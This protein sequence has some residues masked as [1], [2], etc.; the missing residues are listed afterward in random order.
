MLFRNPASY[1]TMHEA[2]K[3]I[4]YEI[5]ELVTTDPFIDTNIDRMG[6]ET[7]MAMHICIHLFYRKYV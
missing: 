7:K 1:D 2:Q 4:K 3:L 6:G 5:E